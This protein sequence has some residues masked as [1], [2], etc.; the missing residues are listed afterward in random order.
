MKVARSMPKSPPAVFIG[1][2]YRF[3]SGNRSSYSHFVKNI[4]YFVASEYGMHSEVFP[5]VTCGVI[6][7]P[8]L[9]QPALVLYKVPERLGEIFFGI[10]RAI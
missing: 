9:R 5:F 3:I 1:F 2:T 4:L 6:V 10:R 7:P 8:F